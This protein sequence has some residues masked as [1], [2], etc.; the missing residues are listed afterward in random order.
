MAP[1]TSVSTGRKLSVINDNCA[2]RRN[3]AVQPYGR[4][5]VCSLKLN[6]CH[7]WQSSAM[8][9]ALVILLLVPLF[10]HEP[11]MVRLSVAASLLLLV[12]QGMTSHKRTDQLIFGQHE[13]SRTS[14]KLRAANA[15][16]EDARRGLEREVVAR[17]EK[18]GQ[19]NVA[20]ASANLELAELARRREEMVLEV[21]HDL[22]TPLTSVKGAADNLLDGI[23][24]PLGD[25][26]REYVEIV[27]DHAARLIEAVSRLLQGARDQS[28]RVV[29]QPAS[30]EV[31][32]LAR[33][34]VRSLQ[35]IAEERGVAV[36]VSGASVETIADADKLRKVIENLVGNALKFTDRGGSVRVAVEQDA[37][38]IRITVHD[39]GVGMAEGEVDRVFDR[40]YRGRGDRPGS[41]LGLA[42]T[43][44]LVRLHGGDVLARSTP[45]RGSTFS[46]VLPRRAA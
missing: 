12:I 28:V 17:T 32:A 40:F 34:V 31:D 13:L 41:G 5:S 21:S 33:D 18:L 10:A 15:D 27:R 9:F 30:V 46:A 42:I 36:E 39:T 6:Q 16:L 8:S 1:A 20:L 35:P 2:L 25:S 37:A 3:V 22:R 38:D 24:G 19:T 14:E 29:L 26:Q 23:V 4:C 44:D 45:G 11:W 7:A 43:R